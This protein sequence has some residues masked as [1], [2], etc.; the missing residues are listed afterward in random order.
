MEESTLRLGIRRPNVL[1]CNPVDY[2]G[3]HIPHL[4]K[5]KLHDLGSFQF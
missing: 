4:L 1:L 5:E 2:S 3:H